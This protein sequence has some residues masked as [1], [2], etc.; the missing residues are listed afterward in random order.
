MFRVSV[1]EILCR[2]GLVILTSGIIGFD[3]EQK[4][5]PAGMRTHILV[6]IG[7]CIIAMMQ[8]EIAAQAVIFAKSNPQIATVIRADQAR[9]IAQ[10]VSGIGFL[11][12]GTIVVTHHSIRGLTTAALWATAGLGLSIGMGYYAIALLSFIAV[13][14]V[15]VLLKKIVHVPTNKNF[16]IK[17]VN[18]DEVEPFIQEFFK[19]R[20]IKAITTDYAVDTQDDVKIFRKNYAIAFI[21][22]DTSAEIID[23]LAQN[24]NII[25]VRALAK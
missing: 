16:Q 21:S 9:L 24:K 22:A 11:G 6:G 25:A 1:L 5:R 7:A 3:R 2:L 10:V 8:Q 23:G 19:S 4:N 15:L 12:A 13:I 18:P 20:N 14:A 17:Y